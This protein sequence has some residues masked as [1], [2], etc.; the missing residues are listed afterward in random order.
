M[1]SPTLVIAD[2]PIGFASGFGETL[3]N[4]FSGFE[5]ANLWS[6]HPS[7]NTPDK[8]LGSSVSLASP[9]RPAWLPSRLSPAFYPGLKMLQ[10]LAAKRTAADLSNFVIEK[11]IKNL[12]VVPVSPWILS[13]ALRIHR[14]HQELNLILFVMDDWQ[15]H[16]ESYGLPFSGRRRRLLSEAVRR[17]N[18]RFAVSREMAA[19]YEKVYGVSWQIAHNGHNRTQ[20][21]HVTSS[22]KC[23][24][25][26]TNVLLAGD[27]NVFRFDAVLAFGEALERHKQRSGSALE[28]TVFGDVAD[29]YRRPLSRLSVVKMLGRQ[30]QSHCLEAMKTTDLLYLPLAF[31]QKATRISL[32]SLPTKLPEYLASG[33]TM[34]VHAPRESAV[35]RIAERYN[36]NPRL[37]TIDADALDAFVSSWAEG[38]LNE[39]GNEGTKLALTQEFDLGRLAANFQSAFV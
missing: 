32:Y 36:L 6:A 12:L 17:A 33:K 38:N 7:H 30:S 16:H 23:F 13:A 14:Q 25:N 4:L 18:K 19:H 28:L 35:F 3:Y 22:A 2:Y 5:P 20:Q 9:S 29:E 21:T 1:A 34:L 15:G 24:S 11:S 8:K 27:I 26:P 10:F 31:S 37:S 39:V